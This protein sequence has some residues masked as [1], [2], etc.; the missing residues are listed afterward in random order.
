MD[1]LVKIT[2]Q[3]LEKGTRLPITGEGYTVKLY[4][5]DVFSD[6]FLGEAQPDEEGKIAI[7]FNPSLI[8][9]ADSP[10]ETEPDFYFVL[11]R[12]DTLVFKSKVME[13]VNL[14]AANFDTKDGLHFD[15]GSFVIDLQ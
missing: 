3:L 9:S 6:D 4:D 2:A 13:D 1:L 11:L 14:K 7:T 12:N 15:L 10:F 8:S 5:K